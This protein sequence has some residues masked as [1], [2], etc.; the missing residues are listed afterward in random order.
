MKGMKDENMKEMI[1][2][3]KPALTPSSYD[4]MTGYPGIGRK[5]VLWSHLFV[6]LFKT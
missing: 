1:L 3:H 4:Q 5:P 6:L 2:S